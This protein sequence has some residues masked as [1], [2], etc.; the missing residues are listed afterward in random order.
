ML[1]LVGILNQFIL[2]P[3]YNNITFAII[4]FCFLQ[5]EK[6]YQLLLLLLVVSIGGGSYLY[7]FKTPIGTF[8]SFRIFLFLFAGLLLIKRDLRIPRKGV[9]LLFMLFI[10]SIIVYGSIMLSRSLDL[11]VSLKALFNIGAGL[12]LWIVL[13]SLYARFSWFLNVFVKSWFF[14]L[15]LILFICYWEM[16]TGNHLQG[17]FLFKLKSFPSYHVIQ[18]V[19][20][21][22][23][24]N[25]NYLSLFLTISVAFVLYFKRL[26]SDRLA[27]LLIVSSVLVLFTTDSKLSTIALFFIG[28]LF[29]VK[30]SIEIKKFVN[31][32]IKKTLVGGLISAIFLL[33]VFNSEDYSKS[34][35]L[36]NF[37]TT[38]FVDPIAHLGK[39]KSGSSFKVRKNLILNGFDILK[40]SNYLGI[41]PGQYSVYTSRGL[42]KHDVETVLSPHNLLI[43][44]L[45]EYGV[46]IL[47]FFVVIFVLLYFRLYSYFRNNEKI[48]SQLLYLFLTLLI[49]YPILSNNNS[50]FLNYPLNW[51]V[52]SVIILINQELVKYKN[53]KKAHF[54]NP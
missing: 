44:L 52:L 40:K 20:V 30:K 23:F 51:L 41:G 19:P 11:T 34:N 53:G 25:P 13:W 14:C 38:P 6:I 37:E 45:S 15:G 46:F 9:P 33:G 48:P 22:T 39:I 36:N 31:N 54:N 8:Y 7:G 43:E 24:D 32:N 4:H 18:V 29:T 50:S 1:G 17:N 26:V 12:V 35:K 27:I 42:M 3:C 28:V 16:F 49:I 2:F 10:A 47:L 5:K 21:A